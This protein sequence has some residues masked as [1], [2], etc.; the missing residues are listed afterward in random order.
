[1]G[2][3][4]L[5]AIGSTERLPKAVRDLHMSEG[6]FA[7]CCDIERGKGIWVALVTRLAGFPQSGKDVPVSLHIDTNGE[8]WSWDRNFA[9]H[10]T[11]S[12]L[13][14]DTKRECVRESFG[15]VSIWLQPIWQEN[16]MHIKILRLT[17]F[18]IPMPSFSL[19]RSRTHEWQDKAGRFR[20]DV[21]ADAPGLGLLIR[22]QG[23]LT[24]VHATHETD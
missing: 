6:C 4:F 17:V 19:P 10:K 9:G 1:M 16:G 20:F 18:G 7:G 21:S 8:F 11:R 2:D 22:Y 12:T 15:A 5:K 13:K 24:P 14:Y 3:P 23:W